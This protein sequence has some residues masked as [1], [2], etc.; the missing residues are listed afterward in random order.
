M[1]KGLGHSL[2]GIIGGNFISRIGS[3]PDAF[4]L[5]GK[6]VMSVAVVLGIF[7]ELCSLWYRKNMDKTKLKTL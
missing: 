2:G 5:F 6:G 1:Y 7:N 3:L 4:V